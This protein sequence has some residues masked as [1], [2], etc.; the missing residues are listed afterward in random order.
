M[1]AF[2]S[3]KL[4]QMYPLIDDCVQELDRYLENESDTEDGTDVREL[5]AKFSTDVIGRCAFGL[6]F[7]TMKDP[8]S[9]FSG[10]QEDIRGVTEY[11]GENLL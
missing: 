7:N 8:E 1:P 11:R 2:S 3:G 9:V 4:K 5:M 6:D 10:W